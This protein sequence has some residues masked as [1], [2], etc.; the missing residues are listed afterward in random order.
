MPRKPKAKSSPKGKDTTAIRG[1][2]ADIG[3]EHADTFPLS[4]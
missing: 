4:A 3:K 1:I 2:K